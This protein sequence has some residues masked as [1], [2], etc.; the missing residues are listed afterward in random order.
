[1]SNKATEKFIEEGFKRYKEASKVMV[2]FGKQL[3]SKLKSILE[4]R[5][6][7]ANFTKKEARATSTKY[8]LA[9]PLLNAKLKGK[10]KNK[11]IEILICIA[12]SWYQSESDYPLYTL[13]ME[14]PY[15]ND[16]T[17]EEKFST[18]EKKFEDFKWEP[19]CKCVDSSKYVLLN[20]LTAIRPN[21]KGVD[22]SKYVITDKRK[23]PDKRKQLEYH[24]KREDFNLERDF[25]ILLDE[26]NRFLK[27]L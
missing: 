13:W 9:Y 7:W 16:Q 27:G 6:E 17:L 21:C 2:S 24:P 26:F 19:N 25:K 20:D 15:R 23:N 18:L 12:I 10:L 14:N 1:M 22:S 5:N 3:E 4:N 8:G 11:N